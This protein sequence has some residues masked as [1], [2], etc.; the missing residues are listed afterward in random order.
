[1]YLFNSSNTIILFV[2]ASACVCVC[3]CV[4][5]LLCVRACVC[6]FVGGE[7]KKGGNLVARGLC[8]RFV[9]HGGPN[10]YR[11]CFL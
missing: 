7:G 3:V 9:V 8:P 2:C 6:V 5:V 10:E 11:F 1:M 4:C